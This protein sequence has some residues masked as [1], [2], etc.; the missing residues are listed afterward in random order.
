MADGIHLENQTIVISYYD[1]AE[2][3]SRANQPSSIFKIN[4]KKTVMHFRQVL[5]QHAEFCGQRSVTDI[6]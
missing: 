6:V 2:W 5:Q 3:V 1:D 4:F